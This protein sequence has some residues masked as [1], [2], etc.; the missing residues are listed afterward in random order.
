MLLQPGQLY[1]AMVLPFLDVVPDELFLQPGGLSSGQFHILTCGV[2]MD[3]KP[4]ATFAADNG[5]HQ[6]IIGTLR[7][8]ADALDK[9]IQVYQRGSR[10]GRLLRSRPPPPPRL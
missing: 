3:G 6:D 7:P 8:G 1:R 5:L 2:M 4:L 10:R 9:P